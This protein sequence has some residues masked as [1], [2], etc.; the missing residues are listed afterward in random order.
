MTVDFEKAKKDGITKLVKKMMLDLYE[1]KDFASIIKKRIKKGENYRG[2][3][4]RPLESSTL[5]IRRMKGISGSKPLI[6]TGNLL[7]SVKNVKQSN[8]VGFSMAKYGAW[9]SKGFVTNNHFGVKKGNKLVGFRD[10]SDGRR[11]PARPFI[12]PP[13]QINSTITSNDSFAGMVGINKQDAINAIKLLKKA[14]RH[15]K[16]IKIK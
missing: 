9:Q 14:I 8:K 13:N 5:K 4:L 12:Y 16:V 7:N 2:D 1:V 6:E 11:I 15:K 3:R 10:Y